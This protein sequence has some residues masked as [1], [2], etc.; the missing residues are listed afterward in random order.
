MTQPRHAAPLLP[1]PLGEG[2]AEGA[3]VRIAAR[4]TVG[5]DGSAPAPLLNAKARRRRGAKVMEA[6]NLLSSLRLSAPGVLA[7]NGRNAA[8]RIA[9]PKGVPHPNPL[10]KGEGTRR[11]RGAVLALALVTLLVVMLIAGAAV[12]ALTAAHRQGRVTHE[13]LQAQWLAESAVA[14][15]L[16]QLRSQPDYR[17]EAW[18]VQCADVFGVA[19]IQVQTSDSGPQQ[20]VVQAHY[21]DHPWRR[22]AVR[23]THALLFPQR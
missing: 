10:P 15:A 23:R 21:P 17:G 11:R 6:A 13:E 20:I 18:R 16:V 22:V 1:L 8:P 3:S 5:R 14:R 2:Q 9:L 12:R 19:D 7:L 4:R